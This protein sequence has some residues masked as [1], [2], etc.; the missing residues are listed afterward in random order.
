MDSVLETVLMTWISGTLKFKIK[1]K[2][3]KMLVIKK[4]P[5]PIMCLWANCLTLEKN[6]SRNTCFIKILVFVVDICTCG[7]NSVF[8]SMAGFNVRSEFGF[9]SR[10][11]IVLVTKVAVGTS[12]VI[13]VVVRISFGVE[14]VAG[15]SFGV[16]VVVRISFGVEVVAG[17]NFGVEVVAVTIFGV[18]VVART[19]FG[20]ELVAGTRF[21]VEVVAGTSFG[22]EVVVRTSLGIEIVAGTGNMTDSW[23]TDWVVELYR[24][25]WKLKNSSMISASFSVSTWLSSL[26]RKHI[27]SKIDIFRLESFK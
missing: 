14:V 16:E 2:P 7:G 23:S 17:T 6:F 11:G 15:T 3:S 8:D 18:E 20:V 27:C 26:A 24:S 22:V 4:N 5:I 25:F 1:S 9:V 12:L 19:S 13:D 10:V 21:G